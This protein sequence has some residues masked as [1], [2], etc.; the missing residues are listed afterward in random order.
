VEAALKSRGRPRARLQVSG[1]T[2]EQRGCEPA[3]FEPLSLPV[4]SGQP[5]SLVTVT[6]GK[7]RVSMQVANLR[8]PYAVIATPPAAAPGQHVTLL[9]TPANDPPVRSREG[10]EVSFYRGGRRVAAIGSQQLGLQERRVSFALPALPAG[11]IQIALQY[12]R[13]ALA[14]PACQ[15]ARHCEATRVGAPQEVLFTVLKRP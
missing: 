15:G 12:R 9:V 3:F 13:D 8:A 1:V 7:R 5:L 11:P 10:L 14:V 6:D 4:S 2:I